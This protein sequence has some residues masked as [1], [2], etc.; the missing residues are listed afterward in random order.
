MLSLTSRPVY[1]VL[2][3]LLIAGGFF[4][5]INALDGPDS[6]APERDDISTS[7]TTATDNQ[8]LQVATSSIGQ[9]V[10]GRD[11]TA[12]TFQKTNPSRPATKHLLFVG[13]IHGGYEW[14]STVLAWRLIDHLQANPEMLPSSMKI[15]VIPA[16]NPD[17]IF[18]V[19]GTTGKISKTDIPANADP[20]G[21]ERF[22]ASGVDLNRNF[23]CNWEPTSRWRGQQV[24]AG[25]RPFS[26]PETRA[27]RDFVQNHK[28]DG[29]VFFHS[30]AGAVYGA[31]CGQDNISTST[32]TLLDTYAQASGYTA[33]DRFDAYPITGDVES[34]LTKLGIPAV[35]VELTNHQDVEWERNLAGIKAVVDMY[36]R[37]GGE[38]V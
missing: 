2:A 33:V 17:G 37:N 21:P 14:N 25:S 19:T 29:A 5:G 36:V 32:K 23:A 13:G 11:I 27:I 20:G 9:S 35:S 31:A 26:E 4:I 1:L 7:T 12:Y 15:S 6:L 16:A 10:Q 22:N 38:G 28:L 3:V 18:A 24:D 30:A 8:R 34:W